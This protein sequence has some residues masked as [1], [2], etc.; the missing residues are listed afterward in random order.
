[1]I[2]AT[3]LSPGSAYADDPTCVEVRPGVYDVTYREMI[4]PSEFTEEDKEALRK[5]WLAMLDRRTR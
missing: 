5:E 1:M 4:V 3:W 2:S